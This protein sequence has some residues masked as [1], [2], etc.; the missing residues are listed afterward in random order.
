MEGALGAFLAI[1]EAL[2]LGGIA[3][4]TGRRICRR[5]LPD[6]S[7][8]EQS[9]FGFP[10]GMALLSLLTTALLFARV[11]AAGLPWALGA[12][13]A[14][15]ALWAR[16]DAA[17]VARELRGGARGSRALA[18]LVSASALLGV[19]GCL[20]PET[21]WDTGVYHFALS[22]QWAEQGAAIVRKD[23]PHS[24]HPAYLES[25]HAAGFL[26]NGE[27]LA[28]LLNG[29]YYFAGL[30]LV[31]LWGIRV[32][33]PGAGGLAALAWMTSVTFVL[34][35]DGGDTEVAQAVYLTV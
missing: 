15:A 31:R 23:V 6:S 22:R 19:I 16:K 7:G 5:L 14:G 12:A 33:G 10:V 30:A 29:S 26:L 8:L 4:G 27:A 28:S 35:L 18:A 24:F 2:V 13:L 20:A 17:T 21:G 1:P 25:L 34:R 32:A 3:T 11:P 9:A